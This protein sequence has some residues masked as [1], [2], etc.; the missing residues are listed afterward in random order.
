VYSRDYKVLWNLRSDY[1]AAVTLA[2]THGASTSFKSD[3]SK[4]RAYAE[5]RW[6]NA[7]RYV[8]TALALKR[9]PAIHGCVEA[10]AV[11]MQDP[12]ICNQRDAALGLSVAWEI[13]GT[14][15]TEV[16]KKRGEQE[17]VE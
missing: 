3:H 1:S 7:A 6:R 17:V 4:K 11:G 13:E 10:E 2:V 5:T 14:A 12:E 9:V 8:D 15:I 16:E